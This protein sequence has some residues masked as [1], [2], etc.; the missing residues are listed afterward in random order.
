MQMILQTIFVPPQ[1]ISYVQ[2]RHYLSNRTRNT[3]YFN[4]K[5]VF[6]CGS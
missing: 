2:V 1:K 6:N 5:A 3:A 4:L